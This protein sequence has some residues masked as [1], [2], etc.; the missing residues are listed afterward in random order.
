MVW[1]AGVRTRG[2]NPSTRSIDCMN[3]SSTRSVDLFESNVAANCELQLLFVFFSHPEST[4][5]KS[6]QTYV[7]ASRASS[8]A[9][10]LV[11]VTGAKGG[12]LCIKVVGSMFQEGWE[13]GGKHVVNSF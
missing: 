1:E 6:V 11:V 8:H 4:S 12:S 10:R 5:F 2:L 9:P 3:G 13:S 7:G